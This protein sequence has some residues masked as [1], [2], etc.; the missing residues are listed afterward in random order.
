MAATTNKKSNQIGERKL[1]VTV[2]EK[3]LT[4]LHTTYAEKASVSFL[5]R[6]QGKHHGLKAPT[7]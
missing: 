1:V 4:S 7:A 5:E 6:I 3:L 2:P